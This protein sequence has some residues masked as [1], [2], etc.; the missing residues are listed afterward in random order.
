ML[1][2]LCSCSWAPSELCPLVQVL[3]DPQLRA[4]HDAALAA[5]T[6]Q[7]GVFV[8]DE[9]SLADMDHEGQQLSYPCRCGGLFSTDAGPACAAGTLLP[10]CSCS[11]HLQVLPAEPYRQPQVA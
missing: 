8:Y 1:R 7:S 3:Q 9:V 4:A 10:C 11:L 5:Q 2:T 6:L